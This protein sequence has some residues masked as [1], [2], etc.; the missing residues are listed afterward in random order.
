M[1]Q[2]DPCNL[3]NRCK[4][5]HHGRR[6]NR[7]LLDIDA[8]CNSDQAEN[9]TEKHGRNL[10]VVSGNLESGKK[11]NDR[12]KVEEEFHRADYSRVTSSQA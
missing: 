10:R 4:D 1:T 12:E 11:K 2:P 7:R 3:D 8:A 5:H 9:L 6:E